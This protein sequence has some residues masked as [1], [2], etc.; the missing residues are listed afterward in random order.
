[1]SKETVQAIRAATWRSPAEVSAVLAGADVDAGEILQV[2]DLLLHKVLAADAERHALR[3]Q[4]FAALVQRRPDES[5]FRPFVRAFKQAPP[6]VRTVLGDLLPKV[7]QNADTAELVDVLRSPEPEMRAAA[8]RSLVEIAQGPGGKAVVAAVSKLVNE[9]GFAGLKEALDVVVRA[10][11]A[12]AVPLLERVLLHPDPADRVLAARLLGDPHVAARAS[13]QVM[14]ALQ[15]AARDPVEQV[16]IAAVQGLAVVATEADYL[17]VA[18]P[19]VE[20]KDN[21]GLKLAAA[22]LE[23]LRRFPNERTAAILERKIAVGPNTLRFS[24]LAVAE[25]AGSDALL[26]V[27]V[28]A[29]GHPHIAVRN[30]ASEVMSSMARSGR[31]EVGRTIVW[32]L[33]SQDV[34]VRRMAADVLRAVPDPHG[35]L[36]P[37]LVSSL[38]DDDWWVRERV[39]DALVELAGRGLSRYMVAWLADGSDVVR[40]FALSVL[41]RLKDPETIGALVHCAMN[42]SDWW[43]REKAIEVIAEF[44]DP[45]AVPTVIDLMQR[46]P[47]LQLACIAALRRIDAG[48]A[49]PH[50]LPLAQSPDADVRLAVLKLVE[51]LNDASHAWVADALHDDP[52]P[53]VQRLARS[54]AARYSVVREN[55]PAVPGI[56]PVAGGDTTPLDVLLTRVVEVGGD[57]LILASDRQVYVKRPGGIV[58]VTEQP[59]SAERASALLTPLLSTAL[60]LRLETKRDVDFSYAVKATGARFRVN[61]FRQRGGL[62]AV[63]HAVR[64]IVPDLE[65]L[66]LPAP[67]ASWCNFKNGLV[68]VAGPTASGKS[69]TLAALL[70][71]MNRKSSRHIVSIEDPIEVLHPAKL[72]LVNQREVGT[73]TRS[74]AAALRSALREDPD[75]LMIGEMRDKET[76]ALA[77]TAAET[78]H[79]VFGTINTISSDQAVERI[80]NAFPRSEQEQVRSSLADV[81]RAVLCQTL[82]RGKDGN[83]R[84][85]AAE[86]MINNDAIANLIR[87]GKSVQ[88]PSIVATAADAGM[89]TLEQ[90]LARLI[91]SGVVDVDDASAKVRNKRELETARGAP[92][93]PP[94]RPVTGTVKRTLGSG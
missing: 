28:K 91:R 54:V 53:A 4:A 72:S 22:A 15:N 2:L 50:V 79:L 49:A 10:G 93:P 20:S 76:I 63:F 84:H 23:G 12:H 92:E 90:D 6:D 65:Q 82:V 46:N 17:A 11:G 45:R 85:L 94:A 52:D 25:A 55:D 58:A 41:L 18:V 38:R 51:E 88:I 36:W 21:R 1:M 61:L 73:H 32:L 27:V 44:R 75:V 68:L 35:E 9:R 47:E 89:Q 33:R 71:E 57:D 59:V 64:G 66:G 34:S 78:G 56:A 81:L 83:T 40:R 8:A 19:L 74:F 26:G 31:V 67:V 69:T 86:V 5:L 24:A 16:A 62:S 70:D 60:M 43:A 39:M 3:R 42:D 13:S 7:A 87:K 48:A 80:V 77:L 14:H 30:R 37:K 29:L